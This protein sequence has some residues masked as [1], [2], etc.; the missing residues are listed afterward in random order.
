MTTNKTQKSLLLI[1]LV[2]L[3]TGAGIWFFI[4]Q[5]SSAGAFGHVVL[6]SLDTCRADYLS[7]YGYARPTTPNIDA[8]AK[9]GYLF[10]HAMTPVPITLPAHTSMFTGT[11]PP[12]HGKHENK[13]VYFD[14]SHVTLAELLK[15][16]GYSTGAFVGAKILSSVLGLDRG[17]DT[18]DDSFTQSERRAEEVNR[19]AFT[20]LEKQKRNPIWPQKSSDYKNVV[21]YKFSVYP[22]I[23]Y[24]SSLGDTL[25]GSLYFYY[26][27]KIP[28]WYLIDGQ[29][30]FLL[31]IK[32][33]LAK[34]CH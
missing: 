23:E 30:D 1:M 18:Y 11:I 14:P 25:N 5:R 22:K 12:H 20:W 29:F 32:Y 33:S 16:K 34:A 3:L 21:K 31:E 19:A 27:L 7:C 2:I 13:D 24:S 6:I 8:L 17:F 15:A 10:S 9:K 4:Q 28:Y 26:V